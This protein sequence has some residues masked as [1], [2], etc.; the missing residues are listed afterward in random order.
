[1]A[2]AKELQ[3]QGR[4]GDTI[5]AHINKEE[6]EILKDHGGAGTINP[7]TGLMEFNFLTDLWDGFKSIV[8]EYAPV[9]IPA[10]AIF[11]V[12]PL[13]CKSLEAEE[14]WNPDGLAQRAVRLLKQHL[15]E[16]KEVVA[17]SL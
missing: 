11:P 8:K 10:I 15:P 6:V 3:E 4:N 14:A 7:E 1:M 17:E 9:I 2:M 13:E 5:L 12:T 16:V